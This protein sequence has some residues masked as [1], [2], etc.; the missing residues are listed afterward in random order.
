MYEQVAS[1]GELPDDSH[2]DGIEPEV[3]GQHPERGA[4]GGPGS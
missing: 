2:G 4:C 3:V 1:D